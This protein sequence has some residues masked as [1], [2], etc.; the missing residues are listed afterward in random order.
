M[1]SAIAIARARTVLE[2]QLR[3]ATLNRARDDAVRV[4]SSV[5]PKL[6]LSCETAPSNRMAR[7]A[8][9]ILRAELPS[10]ARYLEIGAFEG[11]SLAFVHALLNG[12]VAATVIDPFENY[13]ELPSVDMP[14]VGQRFLA[15]MQA[16][17]AEVRALRGAS[18]ER[19]PE[20]IRERETFDLI[21]IDGSHAAIDVLADAALC[22]RLLAK[23]GLLIFDDY[24]FRDCQNGQIFE[25][26]TA[27]DAFA[28]VVGE[29]A[30]IVDVA[31][32]VFMRRIS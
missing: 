19:L 5:R 16:I 20:L 29:S 27:I 10:P 2:E 15:N 8:R 18:F 13:D 3:P 24:R 21:Y 17:G 31:A 4:W 12:R 26:K 14:S 25:C 22:W 32:Q 30:H 11:A 1:N 23:G 7:F 9:N 28:G 6:T